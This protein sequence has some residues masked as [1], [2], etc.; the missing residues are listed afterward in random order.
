MFEIS[1]NLVLMATIILAGIVCTARL[2]LGAHS[3]KQLYIGFAIGLAS[4]FIA[5][6]FV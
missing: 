6:L 4:Q 3:E 1:T 2:L 5:M